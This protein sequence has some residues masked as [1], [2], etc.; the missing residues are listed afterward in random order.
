MCIQAKDDVYETTRHRMAVAEEQQ[1]KNCTKV[2]KPDLDDIGRK[3]KLTS[4]TSGTSNHSAKSFASGGLSDN[5]RIMHNPPAQHHSRV[6]SNN[7]AQ[8]PGNPE[9]MRRPIR[10]RLIH[11]LALRPYKKPELYDR[12]NRDGLSEKDK[13]M[14]TQVL[15]QVAKLAKDNTYH[16]VRSVW[17]DVQEDW[18]FYTEQDR[19]MLRRRKPQNL[20]PPGSSDTGSSGSGQSPTSTHPGSPPSVTQAP[21]RPGYHQSVDGIESKRRRISHYHKLQSESS[22]PPSEPVGDSYHQDEVR[23]QPY[24]GTDAIRNRRLEDER[25]YLVKNASDSKKSINVNSDVNKRPNNYAVNDV[26]DSNDVNYVSDVKKCASD[27]KP[28]YDQ[29]FDEKAKRSDSPATVTSSQT[30]GDALRPKWGVDYS[31]TRTSYEDTDTIQ[32][33][34]VS[35]SDTIPD[36]L[37]EYTTITNDSQ[38]RRYKEDFY[39]HY[40]EYKNLH[41]IMESVTQKFSQLEANLREIKDRNSQQYQNPM[42]FPSSHRIFTKSVSSGKSKKAL[43]SSNCPSIWLHTIW[44]SM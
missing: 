5:T 44:L 24:G 25:T 21:K 34:T 3:V 42:A 28:M 36:Y 26:K 10:E 30:Q 23:S 11:L 27:A 13:R 39:A 15:S 2:I 29:K 35:A 19:Q 22:R 40:E 37:T 32:E 7:H 14:F 17:N 33:N 20:T 6:A 41:A 16:P 43:P 38:R 4:W 9:L 18:P 31:D 1:K 8:K 12:I